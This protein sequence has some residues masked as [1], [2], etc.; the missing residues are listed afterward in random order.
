MFLRI[1]DWP[2]ITRDALQNRNGGLKCPTLGLEKHG[3]ER[4]IL[5]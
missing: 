4:D 5:L 1:Q 3:N 2:Q